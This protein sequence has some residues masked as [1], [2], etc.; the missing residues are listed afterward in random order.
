MTGSP[1]LDVG[2]RCS[3]ETI[4]L[5]ALLLGFPRGSD[6]LISA[7]RGADKKLENDSRPASN[8]SF[9]TSASATILSETN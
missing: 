7:Q 3:E 1:S 9:S 4:T 5:T 2:P 8:A 6:Q